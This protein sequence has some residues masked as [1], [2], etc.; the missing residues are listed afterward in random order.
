[1]HWTANFDEI[2]DFENDIRNSFGGGGFLA[3]ALFNGP[4]GPPLGAPKAGSSTEL[5]A[6]AAYVSSLTRFGKSP[7]RKPDG[8]LTAAGLRG[9]SL[10]AQLGCAQC[11]SGQAFTDS[12]SGARHDVGTIRPSSGRASGAP[13]TALDTPTL[14]GL[15][16]TA[17]YLHDGS[18][19]DL[20]D[21]LVTRNRQQRHGAT[22]ALTVQ[23]R[24]DLVAYLLQIDDL[25]PA[26]Q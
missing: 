7:H 11:H 25:E 3:S 19:A 10:F 15:W 16:S 18:A 14:R 24:E 8:T 4:Q 6:L 17:P 5:D 22:A 2:Q 20:M 23:Q 9:K 12:P 26:P 13:L 1:V 21:V